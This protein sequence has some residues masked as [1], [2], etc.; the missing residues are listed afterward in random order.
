MTKPLIFIG[1]GGHAAVLMDILIQQGRN[2]IGIVSPKK[3]ERSIFSGV[4]WYTN[5]EDVLKFDCSDV[6]LVNAVGSIP[7]QKLRYQLTNY[8]KKLGY[9]FETV[10]S[11]HAIVSSNATLLEGTQVMHGAIINSGSEIGAYTIIN[12]G[13]IV[14]HDCNIGSENH[15]APG[16]TISGGV[17]TGN[18]VHLGIGSSVIQSVTIGDNSVVGAGA[19][20]TRSIGSNAICYPAPIVKKSLK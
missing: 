1:A 16:V 2:I 19:T 13:A 11:D 3:D 5:D 7:G 20:I 6:K 12:T 4:D 18:Q 8:Y 17:T 14:E 10:I 9:E 15:I